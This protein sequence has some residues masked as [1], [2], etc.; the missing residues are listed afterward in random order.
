M[1]GWSEVAEGAWFAVPAALRQFAATSNACTFTVVPPNH[2]CVTLAGRTP[3]FAVPIAEPDCAVITQP[4]VELPMFTATD[5]TPLVVVA[6]DPGTHS[7]ALL[8]KLTCVPFG[9]LLP[10]LSF[11]RN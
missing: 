3:I 9:T 8:V 5:A 6:A 11:T 10:L 7:P 2:T 4:P 1:N